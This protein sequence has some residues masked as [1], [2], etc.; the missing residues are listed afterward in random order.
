MISGVIVVLVFIAFV[1][2]VAVRWVE[3]QNRYKE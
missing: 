2:R 1:S 3:I